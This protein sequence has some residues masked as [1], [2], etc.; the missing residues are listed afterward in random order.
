MMKSSH[1]HTH[2]RTHTETCTHL[3]MCVVIWSI[4]CTLQWRHNGRDSV[5]NHQPHECLL[6]RLIRRRKHQ[7]SA[8]LAF[9]RGIHRGPVTRPV[10]RK[11][12]SFDDVIMKQ[13]ET[14]AVQWR[15]S[16]HLASCPN[17]FP[18]RLKS[19]TVTELQYNLSKKL[20]DVTI[21]RLVKYDI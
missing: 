1:T 18:W 14:F 19:R 3:S 21:I 16:L 6:N 2:A 15:I 5:S 20:N 17:E 7:S 13:L 12:F 8:S 9:V 11:M 10:T 4:N